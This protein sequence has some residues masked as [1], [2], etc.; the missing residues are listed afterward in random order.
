MKNEAQEQ[1]EIITWF[2]DKHKDLRR[3]LYH[4]YSN[5][6]NKIQGAMLI[7]LGL[8]AGN[9]DLTLAIPRGGFGALYL[10]MKKVGGKPRPEQIK[11][12]ELLRSVGNKV[13]W[14]DNATDAIKIIEN[15]LSL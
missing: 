1:K 4:N 11:Q 9:P 10:E 3:L 14:A 15:Y 13:E 7:G 6:P 2:W 12:M 8:V 5:P